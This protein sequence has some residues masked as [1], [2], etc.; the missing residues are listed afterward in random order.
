MSE[1]TI[2]SRT[3]ERT[4]ERTTDEHLEHDETE[5]CPECGGDLVT[6]SE[7]GETVCTWFGRTYFPTF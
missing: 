7:R 3:A 5:V 4:G 2:Q 6:D 1:S